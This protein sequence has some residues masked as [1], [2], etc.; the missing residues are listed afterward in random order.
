[1]AAQKTAVKLFHEEEKCTLFLAGDREVMEKLVHQRFKI[2]THSVNVVYTAVDNGNKMEDEA[3]P[4][5]VPAE[6]VFDK[7]HG[8]TSFRVTVQ[9]AVQDCSTLGGGALERKRKGHEAWNRKPETVSS[10]TLGASSD[11]R[12]YPSQSKILHRVAG[13][14]LDKTTLRSTSA[15]SLL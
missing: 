13:A 6:A 1:M 3:D 9:P 14:F 10:H 4:L 15:I 2:P 5:I 12:L 7:D 11:N 8:H